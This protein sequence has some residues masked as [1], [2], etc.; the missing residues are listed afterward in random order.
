MG[1]KRLPYSCVSVTDNPDCRVP[2][3]RCQPETSRLLQGE[4]T[5]NVCKSIWAAGLSTLL[6][7]PVLAPA[8]VS[9][10]GNSVRHKISHETRQVQQ[11]ELMLARGN[12]QDAI[13][14]VRRVS[15][16]FLSLRS[17]P[18]KRGKGPG[19][20]P[21]QLKNRAQRVAALAVARS[22]GG[23]RLSQTL[24]GSSSE[25]KQAALAWSVLVFRVHMAKEPNHSGLKAQ[26]AE[27]LSAQSS[28]KTEAYDILRKLADDDLMP[29]A[30]GYAT[31]AQ[32]EEARGNT[33]ARDAA[34]KRCETI[35]VDKK[36]CELR[37]DA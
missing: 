26:L 20:S 14:L 6:A 2:P 3:R 22:G 16:E 34:T 29:T 1:T 8:P 5:V 36:V 31:L 25:A 13:K 19:M 23:V 28:G 30:H 35:A 24:D 37:R 17:R 21:K 4:S 10:C 33:E 12:Y 11:A 32:L 18:A 7:L 27:A 15:P 9:A